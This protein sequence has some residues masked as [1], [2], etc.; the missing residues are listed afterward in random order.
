M[1][2]QAITWAL[3]QRV[4]SAT[5]KAVLLVL[6]NRM[7]PSGFGW[8]SQKLV[9]QEAQCSDRTV[10]RVMLDLEAD[11]ILLRSDRRRKNGSFT[12]DACQ[13]A[14]QIDPADNLAAGEPED[15]LA[16]GQSDRRSDTT[17]P[18][19]RLSG[20]TS[21][22]PNTKNRKIFVGG[23]PP[24]NLPEAIEAYNEAAERC[25]WVKLREFTE[26]RRVAA[27]N[28]WRRLGGAEGWRKLLEAASEQSFLGGAN[29]DGWR[30]NF[31]FLV[32]PSGSA[33]I[34]EGKYLTDV[35]RKRAPAS[36]ADQ[37]AER[38]RIFREQGVWNPAW[39]D[40]PKSAGATP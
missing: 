25:G 8:P 29:K 36:A 19:D 39:G 33:N 7:D 22:E 1:S 37:R 27:R 3:K 34:L 17:A 9:A 13:F 23:K 10:R 18:A 14:M 4:R 6:A 15:N 30:M 2:V 26:A 40:P 5:H 32:R 20:P 28:A 38:E 16:S 12:T 11:G 24:P 31:D 21:F 35:E